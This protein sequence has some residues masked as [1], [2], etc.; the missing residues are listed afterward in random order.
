MSMD[1]QTLHIHQ[2]LRIKEDYDLNEQIFRLRKKIENLFRA[3][4]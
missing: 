4:Q 3:N 2:K 1:N